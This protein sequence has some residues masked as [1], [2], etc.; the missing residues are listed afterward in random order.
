MKLIKKTNKILINIIF[1][2]SLCFLLSSCNIINKTMKPSEMFITD[3]DYPVSEF[4]PSKKEYIIAPFDRIRINVV[5]NIGESYFG[6]GSA[7]GRQGGEQ[8]GI[9]FP[10]EY[11]GKVKAPILGRIEISGKTVREAEAM[12][13]ERYSEYFVDP[14]VLIEVTNRRIMV[15]KANGTNASIITMRSDRFTLIEAIAQT[16]GLTG[17]SK[18]YRIK[19]IRGDLTDNPRVYYWNIRNLNELKGS[20]ILL[21]ANDIIY[22]D[23]RPQY[24]SRTIREITPWLTLMTTLMTVYGLFFK[25]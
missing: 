14:F 15:F 4:E 1:V 11:D 12:F 16:G 9:E 6:T 3:K 8:G 10:V 20:N 13:E 2:L 5:S 21:E 25:L 23:S 7:T 22:I 24:V 19:L 18:S 17:M